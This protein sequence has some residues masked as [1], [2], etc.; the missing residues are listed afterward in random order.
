MCSMFLVL[1]C[2]INGNSNILESR[3]LRFKELSGPGLPTEE[4]KVLFA[5]K[6]RTYQR[7]SRR[8]GTKS[9]TKMKSNIQFGQ[10]GLG[11]A[12]G[13]ALRSAIKQLK[14]TFQQLI[15]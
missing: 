12:L 11:M 8:L 13:Q 9:W 3:T 10:F 2:N 4:G 1:S 14:P 6:A 5:P 15:L 7:W